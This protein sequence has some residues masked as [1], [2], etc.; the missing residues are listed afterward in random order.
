MTG[1]ADRPANRSAGK[2]AANRTSWPHACRPI[3][4]PADHKAR[5]VTGS[6]STHFSLVRR[7]PAAS[8]RPRRPGSRTRRNHPDRG[9][10]GDAGQPAH[11][12]ALSP[13]SGTA[14][15]A[16]SAGPQEPSWSGPLPTSAVSVRS[17][18][19]APTGPQSTRARQVAGQVLPRESIRATSPCPGVA[20]LGE[21]DRCLDQPGL[22]RYRALVQFIAVTWEACFYS[23]RLVSPSLTLTAP[24]GSAR[25]GPNRS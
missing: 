2:R 15:Y 22:G 8:N 6:S 17:R 10:S 19:P 20:A 16:G 3:G 12:L 24:G 1:V 9:D 14:R 7:G 4:L 23:R 21:T 18:A 13:W 25:T 5:H 11:F